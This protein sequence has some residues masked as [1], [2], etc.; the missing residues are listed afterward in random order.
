MDR[1]FQVNRFRSADVLVLHRPPTV[2]MV[3]GI[4]TLRPIMGLNQELQRRLQDTYFVKARVAYQHPIFTQCLVCKLVFFAHLFA[5]RKAQGNKPPSNRSMYRCCTRFG[6]GMVSSGHRSKM[7]S[8]GCTETA[9]GIHH[10]TIYPRTIPAILGSPQF[11][12]VR[13]LLLEDSPPFYRN[14]T[15]SS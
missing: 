4:M 15:P 14:S 10:S 6:A 5:Y 9:P 2:T 3:F 8:T 12:G 7:A 11:T 13:H 1:G